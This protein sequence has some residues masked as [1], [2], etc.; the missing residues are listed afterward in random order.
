MIAQ[1]P[2]T[3][4]SASAAARFEALFKDSAPVEESITPTTAALTEDGPTMMWIVLKEVYGQR[5]EMRFSPVFAANVKR[6]LD[7][8]TRYCHLL[9]RRLG[10][11]TSIDLENYVHRRQRDQWRGKP[12]TN[13]TI[14]NEIA[15]LN[16]VFFYCG[17][18]QP[19]GVGRRNLG[20]LHNPPYVEPLPEMD[21]A[22]VDLADEQ[23]RAFVAATALAKSPRLPGCSPQTFWI[24]AL[25]LDGITALRRNALL[26]IP[27]PDDATLWE[28]RELVLPAKL[29]KTRKEL[30]ISLGRNDEVLHL[31]ASLPSQPGEPF[32]PWVD[33]LGRRMSESHF[34]AVMRQFQREAGIK[35]SQRVLTKH[36]R[37][38]A[39][40]EILDQFGDSVA[41]KKLGHG[42]KSNVIHTNY[43]ARKITENDRAATD[44]LS[45][46]LLSILGKVPDLKL[47]TG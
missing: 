37:S 43:Q 39:A 25:I 7:R 2:Y 8:F 14:N 24:A 23:L 34:N 22:P 11:I 33:R 12:L 32:L 41:K 29:N 6:V 18:K 4:A 19:R 21:T 9:E 46:R 10:S 17:P 13:T 26:N 40:T 38:T 1:N 44:A 31:L 42:P 3:L 30:R 15:I 36:L 45:S 27:R 35:D 20:L 16:S 5:C 47:A 28:L